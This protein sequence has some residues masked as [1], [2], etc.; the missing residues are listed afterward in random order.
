LGSIKDGEF[1]DWVIIS[2]SRKSMELVN[3]NSVL[4]FLQLSKKKLSFLRC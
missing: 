1:I 4:C 2:F 3:Y